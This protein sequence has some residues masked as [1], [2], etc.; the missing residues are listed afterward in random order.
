MGKVVPRAGQAQLIPTYSFRNSLIGRN[1]MN[2]CG[3]GHQ[4][5][6]KVRLGRERKGIYGGTRT[7]SRFVLGGKGK[8]FTGAPGQRKRPHTTSTPPLSLHF[9]EEVIDD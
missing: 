4:D 5:S 2:V 1:A 9:Q 3:M 7:A 6:V 8:V